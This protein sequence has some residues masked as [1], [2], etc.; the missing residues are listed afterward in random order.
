M[1]LSY[2]TQMVLQIV[3]LCA[4]VLYHIGFIAL[5]SA[6]LVRDHPIREVKACHSDVI[7]CFVE[8]TSCRTCA[9]NPPMCG[10]TLFSILCS[11]E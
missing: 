1:G 5:G 10:S 7:I 3:G 11:L 8:T 2:R 4:F 6:A 9:E